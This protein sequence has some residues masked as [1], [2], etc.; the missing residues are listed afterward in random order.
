MPDLDLGKVVGSKI[1]FT[2]GAPGTGLGLPNDWALDTGTGCVYE[3]TGAA[4]WTARGSFKGEKGDTGAVGPQGLK[5]DT[6]ETGPQGLKG[7]KGDTGAAGPRGETGPQGA[8]G[9]KGETGAAGADGQT[10]IFSINSEG[11][12]IATY[13]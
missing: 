2:N 10:P 11:H 12:L 3:K 13:E 7:D 4:V 5:G 6:G 8:K 1:H 9:D